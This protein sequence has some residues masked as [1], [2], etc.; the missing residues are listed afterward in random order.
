MRPEPRVVIS[1]SIPLA[2]YNDF[3]EIVDNDKQGRKIYTIF[4]EMI[5]IYKE[6]R[7]ND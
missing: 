3:Y 1:I 7:K 6:V 5:R 4:T 2:V